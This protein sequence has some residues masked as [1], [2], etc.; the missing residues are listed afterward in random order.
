VVIDRFGD[1]ADLV[2]VGERAGEIT[3][4][5]NPDDHTVTNCPVRTNLRC[6]GGDI[7]KD[8]HVEETNS[9]QG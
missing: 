4:L 9:E 8:V 7:G 2:H 5:D 1:V 3:S 6:Y